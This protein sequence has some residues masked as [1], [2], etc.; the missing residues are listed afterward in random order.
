MF[1]SITPVDFQILD[2]I[3]Q[4][5]R[6]PFMDFLMPKISMIGE[7]GI[8]WLVIG[9]I[10]LCFRKTRRCAIL[11]LIST[12]AVYCFGELFLKN[13][14]CR[15]RPCN[16]R[17]Y[18]DIP[19]ER[20]SSYSFPSGHTSS[21]F[22]CAVMILMNHRVGGVFALMLAIVIAFSR[23]YNY[24]HFPSDVLAGALLGAV[25]AVI[26]YFIARLVVPP[27]RGRI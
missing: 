13:Q 7:F 21:A 19:V 11:M 22:S 20:P 2:W 25:F 1:S 6:C 18:L 23:L 27:K 12:L 4:N 14:I 16:I 9:I 24:V 15:V 26:T 8:V 5:L 17:P 3:Q 10:M